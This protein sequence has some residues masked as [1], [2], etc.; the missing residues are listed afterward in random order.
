MEKESIIKLVK[1][2][3]YSEETLVIDEYTEDVYH[4]QDGH[5]HVVFVKN[6]KKLPNELLNIIYDNV[7]L[8]GSTCYIRS[9]KFRNKLNSLSIYNINVTII[10]VASLLAQ[11]SY[12]N[13]LTINSMV[14][15]MSML[16]AWLDKDN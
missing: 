8:T 10:T 7:Y 9:K 1:S 11:I 14:C 6:G 15:L 3:N 4:D 2:L 12:N 16:L 5:D 13:D